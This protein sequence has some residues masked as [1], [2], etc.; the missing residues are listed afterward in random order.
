MAKI[1]VAFADRAYGE[2]I[3]RILSESGYQVSRVCTSG[4]EVL[5]LF[6]VLQDGVLVCGFRLKDRLVDQLAA[7]LG[8][9]IEILCL[10]KPQQ[11]DM[12]ET[13]GIVK[14]P[15]PVSKSAFCEAVESLMRLH[16]D[17]LP[18]RSDAADLSV[19]QAKQYLM[20]EDGMSEQEAH[21]F[22]Q[23]TSMRHGIPMRT[24]AEIIL[25]KKRQKS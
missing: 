7:D 16:Y 20:K 10:S 15:L 5:R 23:K 18:H 4:S 17:N 11:L 21:R 12:I 9:H 8:D 13:K 19:R 2:N 6:H 1:A 24:V 22:L 14:I 25:E 3:A